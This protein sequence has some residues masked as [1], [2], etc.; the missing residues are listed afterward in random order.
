MEVCLQTGN[1]VESSFNKLK[2]RPIY[3]GNVKQKCGGAVQIPKILCKN[4]RCSETGRKFKISNRFI[5][6]KQVHRGKKIQ[7][8]FPKNIKKYSSPQLLVRQSRFEGGLLAC[9]GECSFQTVPSVFMERK[10]LAVQSHALWAGSSTHN[11]CG[12]NEVPHESVR[13]G[14]PQRTELPRRFPNMGNV[15]ERVQTVSVESGRGTIKHRFHS[16]YPQVNISANET[17]CLARGRVELSRNGHESPGSKGERIKSKSHG[18]NQSKVSKS[19]RSRVDYRLDE[20]CGTMAERSKNK[21]KFMLV[22]S[23]SFSGKSFKKSTDSS[24]IES[25]FGMVDGL[26]QCRREREDKTTR[27]NNMDMDRCV[28][29][30]MGGASGIRRMCVGRMESRTKKDAY[31]SKGSCSNTSGFTEVGNSGEEIVKDNNRQ[32]GSRVCVEEMGIEEVEEVNNGGRKDFGA[33]S[34]ERMDGLV[35]SPSIFFECGG[36]WFVK[37]GTIA[38]RMVPRS[39]FKETGVQ[40]FRGSRN[41]FDGDTVQ[42]TAE[43]VC[44]RVSSCRGEGFGRSDGELGR[45]EENLHIS[46]TIHD[47]MDV[48]ENPGVQRRDNLDFMSPGRIPSLANCEKQTEKDTDVAKPTRSV[49]Q[50]SMDRVW[51]DWREMDCDKFIIRNLEL[52]MDR[53]VAEL[54]VKAKRESTRKQRRTPWRK[55]TKWCE[56]N[57]VG[58]FTKRDCLNFLKSLIDKGSLSTG[59]IKAYKNALSLPWKLVGIDPNSWEFTHLIKSSFL[60]NPPRARNFPSWSLTKVLNMLRNYNVNENKFQLLKKTVF[61]VA[62]ATGNRCS[63]IA[64]IDGNSVRLEEGGIV[65]AV[66]PGFIYKNQRAGRFPPNLYIKPLPE[67]PSLCP[68]TWLKNYMVARGSEDGSLF[69]NSVTGASLTAGSISHILARVINEADPEK[70][71]KGHDV[72]K[73][74]TSLAWARGIS[75]E[76]ICRRTFWSSSNAFITKYL[77]AQVKNVQCVAVGSSVSGEVF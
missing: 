44:V 35:K 70:V 61:L 28:G 20:F 63:E 13:G 41:R 32:C 37:G 23:Q 36:R 52:E 21:Q 55:F 29:L 11:I 58:R 64:A 62:L 7:I 53:G 5:C 57:V 65:M 46:S 73:V 68:V 3:R 45:V 18:F 10:I 42:P 43:A 34:E 24:S 26:Q 19:K 27:A 33:L 49:V 50:R 8:P 48:K 75:P 51:E 2:F 60:I 31:K 6:F 12:Y 59:T 14:E 15:R 39:R 30:R 66:K 38:R 77:N 47:R 74:A 40:V 22:S 25:R 76:E 17:N 16:Q 1:K 4:F 69:K 67:D 71:A 9:T 72:R 56:S 54:I